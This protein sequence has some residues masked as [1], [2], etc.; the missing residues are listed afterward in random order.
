LPELGKKIAYQANRAGVAERCDAPAVHKTIEVDLAL[1]TSDDELLQDLA[2]SLLQT[3]KHHAAQTLDLLHTGPGIGKI[4]RLVWRYER[5]RVEPFP[6][7][8]DFA[9]SGRL[10]KCR[11]ASGGKRLGPSGKKMGT[12]PLTWAFSAAATLFWRNNPQG[13]TLLARLEK[14]HDQGK[15]LS[16]LAHQLGRAVY[17]MLKRKVAFELSIFLQT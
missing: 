15:A 7:V 4:L 11:K 6:R 8:Q 13:Q 12:A 3:A 17:V 5:H 14:T 10:G 9:S 2:R 1:L 16:S